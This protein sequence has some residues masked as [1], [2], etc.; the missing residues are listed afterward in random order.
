MPRQR[1]R[2]FQLDLA[3]ARVDEQRSS[4]SAS[5]SLSINQRTRIHDTILRHRTGRVDHVNFALSVGTRIPRSVHVFDLPSDV[6]EFVPRFRGYKYI[7]VR[8]EI[9]IIDP[10]TLEIVAVIPA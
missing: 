5:V 9:V 6:V 2:L 1:Q 4:T 7:L 10:D 8:D 3:G